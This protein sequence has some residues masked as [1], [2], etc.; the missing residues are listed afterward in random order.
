MMG[1]PGGWGA[2][3]EG[4]AGGRS[5]GLFRKRW[6][7]KRLLGAGGG[8]ALGSWAAGG[9]ERFPLLGDGGARRAGQS[10]RATGCGQ[11]LPSSRAATTLLPAHL[12]AGHHVD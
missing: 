7:R 2:G 3:D 1:P 9:Q 12:D 8:A 11:P 4:W 6:V 10:V 5:G